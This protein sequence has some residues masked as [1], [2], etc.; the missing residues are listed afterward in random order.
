LECWDIVERSA[1][2]YLTRSQP[3]HIG[4]ISLEG[5]AMNRTEEHRE[6]D[7]TPPEL[8]DTRDIA[9]RAVGCMA[10]WGAPNDVLDPRGK[11]AMC[12]QN[13]CSSHLPF[14]LYRVW[15]HIAVMKP[16]GLYVNLL[17]NHSGR[18]CDVRDYQPGEGRVEI[19]MKKSA[20]LY[21]RL[22][23]WVEKDNV[24]VKVG[25]AGVD[26]AWDE[27]KRYVAVGKVERGVKLTIIYPLRRWK[28]KELLGGTVYT[29]DWI[30]D[31]VVGIDP[32]GRFIPV[33]G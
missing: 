10:G 17:L 2:N 14:G 22:P 25:N 5:V 29:T 3:R 15:E 18:W 13:C 6:I 28:I 23:E 30:G 1:R 19:T 32:A 7:R 33:F 20:N 9:R 31:T 26:R 21:V 27:S 11:G 4:P 12:V 8:C 24:Q 16:E